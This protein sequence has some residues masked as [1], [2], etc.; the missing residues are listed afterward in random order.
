VT[1]GHVFERAHPVLPQVVENL[2]IVEQP[3]AVE[4]EAE[5]GIIQ[6]VKDLLGHCVIH[7]GWHSVVPADQDSLDESLACNREG[8]Q[9]EE[10]RHAEAVEHGTVDNF[11]GLCIEQ[12][13]LDI[14]ASVNFF[15]GEY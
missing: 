9:R 14:T 13:N 6:N 12:V 15:I 11:E 8:G 5:R 7:G 3:V 10:H 1:R 2:P 4:D